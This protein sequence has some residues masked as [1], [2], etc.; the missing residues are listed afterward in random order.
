MNYQIIKLLQAYNAYSESLLRELTRRIVFRKF[1]P[2]EVVL[3]EGDVCRYIYFIV[4]G[5][6]RAYML[7]GIKEYTTWCMLENDLAT[8]ADSFF[9]QIPAREY[10]EASEYTEVIC[11]SYEDYSLLCDAFPVF[12]KMVL[13]LLGQYYAKFYQRAVD[14]VALTK[15]ERYR[16]LI[17]KEPELARRLQLTH[18]KSYLNMSQASLSRIRDRDKDRG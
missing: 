6:L 3:R 12:Q 4:K 2:G 7:R 13:K 16:H 14:L 17:E 9:L 5:G 18:I 11:L 8:A 1:D 15:E 10:I